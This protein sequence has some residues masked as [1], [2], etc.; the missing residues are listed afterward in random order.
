MLKSG[1][2]TRTEQRLQL[3]PL[4]QHESFAAICEVVTPLFFS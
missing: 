1:K 4:V 2:A 3:M